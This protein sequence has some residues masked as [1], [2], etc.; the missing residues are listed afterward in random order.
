[1]PGI[2]IGKTG[3]SAWL[4]YLAVALC[5][6]SPSLSKA[7]LSTAMPHSGGTYNFVNK[8]FGPL[9]G[10]VMGF[11]LWASLLLKSAFALLGFGAYLRVLGGGLP[12]KPIAIGCLIVITVLNLGG[13]KKVS[14]AQSYILAISLAGLGMLIVGSIPSIQSSQLDAFFNHGPKGFIETV[15][16]LFVSYAGVTKVAAIAGEVKDPGK[17]LPRAI[18]L[19][20]VMVTPIYCLVTFVLAGNLDHNM[21]ATD[22][23]PIYTLAAHLGGP[24][25]GIIAAVIAILTMIAMANSGLLAS[26]R[27]PFA[28]SRDSL[29]PAVFSTVSRKSHTPTWCIIFTSLVMAVFIIGVEITA[30]IKL[31]SAFKILA[32]MANEISLI[33]LRT[34]SPQWYKPSYSA[35]F[36]PWL[37]IVASTM[38]LG[39]LV[40]MG[41]PSIL[42]I[43]SVFSIGLTVYFIY[44]RRHTQNLGMLRKMGRRFDLAAPLPEQAHEVE[45][46]IPQSAAACV[47]LI[48]QERSVEMLTQVGTALTG[49]KRVEVIHITDIPDQLALD[50][51]LDEDPQIISMRRRV[52]GM[53]EMAKVDVRFDAMVSHDMVATVHNLSSRLHCEWLVMSSKPYR[54]INPLGWLYNHLPNDLA[55]FKDA[56]IRYIRRILVVTDPSPMDSVVAEA[57]HNLSQYYRA[58]IT[59]TRFIRNDAAHVESQQSLAYLQNIRGLCDSPSE[60]LLLRGNTE[61]ETIS[62]ASKGYDLMVVGARPHNT[63]RNIF[64]K[65]SEDTLLDRSICSALLLKSPR[66]GPRVAPQPI[67]VIDLDDYVQSELVA[68]HSQV[69]N[70]VQLFSNFAQQFAKYQPGISVDDISTALIDRE[71]AQNTGVCHGVGMPHATLPN[72]DRTYLMLQRLEKPLDY[73]APDNQPVDL[74]FATLGPPTDR[75]LHLVLL[76]KISKLILE[77]PILDQIRSASSEADIVETLKKGLNPNK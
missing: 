30:I 60:S 15:S 51:M 66:V 63:I 69:A 32:F 75:Q 20:I 47:A 35:P 45:A 27:F 34:S 44:G 16:F 71:A 43:V 70:K 6:I 41:M 40:A 62:N 2:A 13:V 46:I 48:G 72:L 55:L 73:D 17:N 53:R 58:T 33:I 59:F 38:C 31:A 21:L 74:V 52:L 56:G 1:M 64:L 24:V 14:Q 54:F 7:E 26:S 29:L 25:I 12:L 76:A 42:C 28:M 23:R 68:I 4:A 19:S 36:F 61:V 9:L 39:L 65:S 49:R 77:T 67:P 18:V 11:G 22:I 10:T 3:S 5:I 8:A 37:Q 57:A 50:E